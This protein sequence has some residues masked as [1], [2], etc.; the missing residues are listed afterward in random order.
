MNTYL[1]MITCLPRVLINVAVLRVLRFFYFIL[2]YPSYF[3]PLR[4]L[5]GPNDHNLLLG[6][7]VKKFQAESPVDIQLKWMR[8]WPDAPFIRY[9]SFA[10]NE[11]LLVNSLAAY[12]AVLQTHVYD[13]IKPP[14]FARL[15]GEITGVGLLFAEGES[16]KH[17]RRLLAGP[18]SVPSMR[19]LL[20]VFREKAKDLSEEFEK[21]LGNKPY[22]AVETIETLSK[23][24]M[25]TIGVTVLGI[26]LDT[27]SS[28]YPQSFQELYGRVLHQGPIGQLISVVNAFIPIRKFLPFGANR[29]FTQATTDLREMLR[30]IIQKR[31]AELADGTFKEKK[32][33]SRDLLTYM[34]EEAQLRQQE[35]HKQ[36]WSV[37]DIIGHVR[38]FP[39]QGHES[40]ATTISW[41][42]YV[43]ATN[44]EIQN[45]LRSE[46]ASLLATN[47]NPDYDAISSLPF[48][49]NFVRE[50]LRVFPPSY[51]AQRKTT[52]ALTIE[53]VLIP[54]G[55]Q[56]DIIIPL[57]HRAP[58]IWGPDAETF[59]P[60]R[61]TALSGNAASPF[62]F[63]AFLQ[64]PR[65]CPGRN[66]ALIEVKAVLVEL[67]SKWRFLGVEG[68]GGELLMGG[69]ERVGKGVKIANPSLTYRPAD[70]LFVRFERFGE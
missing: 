39:F 30:D 5:P 7:E 56:I 23:S 16:H 70:G 11:V 64:G 27:L 44:H 2:L 66:F 40:T 36:V 31:T 29:R 1:H 26:D 53:N 62:A 18:F 12:K 32:G 22:A 58:S 14:F 37:D 34:L 59:N 3:S 17:E 61:W 6:Q 15:V 65:I 63:E 50:V 69:E 42:L 38:K 45:R 41:S 55:T 48:L 46:I 10:G 33:E 9:R 57:A 21:L 54:Q 52:R 28:M 35:T 47:P 8:Q 68:S 13:F 60:D 43:L 49:H 25:D 19:K 67:V 51:M 20:P 4:H 24:T